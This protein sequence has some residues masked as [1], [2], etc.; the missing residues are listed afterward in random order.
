MDFAG[1]LS[2][3]ELQ[4]QSN[5]FSTTLWTPEFGWNA[6]ES[7]ASQNPHSP[8]LLAALQIFL[9]FF[10]A[11]HKRT[12]VHLAAEMQA[13]KT[14]VVSAL[15]R[16]M[17]TNAP[18]VRITPN[19]IFVLTGM[20]DNAWT[21]QTMERLPGYV[22]D[23]VAHNGSFPRIQQAL[24]T[25]AGGEYL[26]NVLIVFDESHIA[27]LKRN[28][29]NLLIYDEVARLCPRDQW[30]ERN[31]HFLT[32]S[33]TDPAKSSICNEN[34]LISK[35]VRLLTNETYQ[36][37]EKL[38]N[39]GRIRYN[40]TFGDLH[41]SRAIAELQRAIGQF[42]TPL[43]HILR[44]RQGNQAK[45][46]ELLK[47][48][49]PNCKI[50][51]WDSTSKI[52]ENSTDASSSLT[53]DIN[54]LLEISPNVHTFI[55]LKNMFYA[56]KTM[57]DTNVGILWDRKGGKDD[58][59]LQSLLGRALGYGKST[60]T[61]VYTSKET[62]ENYLGFWRDAIAGL[63]LPRNI[64]IERINSMDKKMAGI[65]KVYISPDDGKPNMVI[66]PSYMG[67]GGGTGVAPPP[68]V[69]K[70]PPNV[71]EFSTIEAIKA[72]WTEI[73]A[74]E[75][76]PTTRRTPIRAP[77]KGKADGFYKCAIGKKSDKQTA[78]AVRNFITPN[79][80]GWGSGL[81]E[82]N[83]GDLVHRVY[84]GYEGDTPIFFLRWGR[85]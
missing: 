31:I 55:L 25:L 40:D 24:R 60:R 58:T 33:A 9:Y 63:P 53:D 23:G 27:S 18:R 17:F 50:I 42:D 29:P 32:I 45:V 38:F 72:R 43:Y 19:R 4:L 54:G 82:A 79:W 7:E 36:S 62:V 12:W 68:V 48:A 39:S 30:I 84:A 59:N 35:V 5:G 1:A 71:E 81:T 37:V 16:L 44:P 64:P 74:A 13:G 61:I 34:R 70:P 20:S 10:I 46:E 80:A 83:D 66:A 49:V 41:E 51:P 67:P 78:T 21:K 52:S 6:S 3:A 69:E 47:L 8:Q 85:K 76:V 26:E 15:I 22:R 56:S 11:D 2:D 28:R 57:D 75:G 77:N 65:Q 73:Q 14:G